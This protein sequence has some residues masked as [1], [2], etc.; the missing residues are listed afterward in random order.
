MERLRAIFGR[1]LAG[2]PAW[3]WVLII[4]GTV[5]AYA[6][7]SRRGGRGELAPAPET[8][9]YPDGGLPADAGDI[10]GSTPAP[11][12][13]DITLTT[14]SAWLRYVVDRMRILGEDPTLVHN[15][16]TKVFAGIAVTQQ[17]NAM[18]NDVVRRFGPPPE[19]VPPIDVIPPPA[20]PP[21]APAPPA[22]PPPA[23]P[24]PPPAPVPKPPPPARVS[25]P[26]NLDLYDWTAQIARAY[27]VPYSLQRMRELNPG[28]DSYIK[29]LSNGPGRPKTPIFWRPTPPVR[30]R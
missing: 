16:V 18:W 5:T 14:N 27:S 12:T 1:R 19:S 9:P 13:G 22:A 30:I 15:A 11:P 29:W 2:A 23:A 21:P 26:W 28:I 6:Y 25:V 4:A 7:L 24:P 8:L 10:P 3:L 17:E 20:A